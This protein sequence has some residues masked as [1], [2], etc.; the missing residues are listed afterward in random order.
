MQTQELC[1]EG[2]EGIYYRKL[3]ETDSTSSKNV[4]KI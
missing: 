3:Q 2:S 4:A 1:P